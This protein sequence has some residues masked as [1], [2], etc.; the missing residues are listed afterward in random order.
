MASNT[1]DHRDVLARLAGV[2]ATTQVY[3]VPLRDR[4]VECRVQF[5]VLVAGALHP[6]AAAILESVGAADTGQ[7]LDEVV[8][9]TGAKGPA[10]R[11]FVAEVLARLTHAR[12]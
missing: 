3:F 1:F 2:P 8:L 7:T 9:A 5:H 10:G 11:R 12:E 6:A 4:L